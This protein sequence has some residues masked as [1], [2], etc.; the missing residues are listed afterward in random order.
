MRRG[1]GREG[2]EQIGEDAWSEKTENMLEEGIE[3]E[4]RRGE[5][6]KER[7]VIHEQLLETSFVRASEQARTEQLLR[8]LN[9]WASRPPVHTKYWPAGWLVRKSF[10]FFIGSNN[11]AKDYYWP[12]L[13]CETWFNI[14]TN[15]MGAFDGWNMLSLGWSVTTCFL[16][17]FGT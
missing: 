6:G 9:L 14:Y 15:I 3:K 2:G 10:S 16:D 4:A 8:F 12:K 7:R 11:T 5:A 17:S 13:D 1:G